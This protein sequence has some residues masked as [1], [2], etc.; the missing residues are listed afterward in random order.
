MLH[1]GRPRRRVVHEVNIAPE[2]TKGNTQPEWG[3][4]PP[5]VAHL[6]LSG[7][8][9]GETEGGGCDDSVEE[10]GVNT[11]SGGRVGV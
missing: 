3:A 4:G 11:R 7:A 6:L 10:L 8:G 2:N 5:S 9:A 1:Q